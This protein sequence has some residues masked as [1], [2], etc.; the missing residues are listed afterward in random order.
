MGKTY[1]GLRLKSNRNEIFGRK[2]NVFHGF[3]VITA[4]KINL[5]SH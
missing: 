1:D 4:K 5:L 2:S 3:V